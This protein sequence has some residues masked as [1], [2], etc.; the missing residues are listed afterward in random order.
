MQAVLLGG[1]SLILFRIYLKY[2]RPTVATSKSLLPDSFLFLNKRGNKEVRI[3]RMVTTFFKINSKLPLHL[4][5][6]ACRSMY[7]TEAANL[8]T[9][10]K[11]SAA[12]KNAVTFLGGHGGTVV[13]NNYLKVKVADSVESSRHLMS[14]ISGSGNIFEEEGEEEREEEEDNGNCPF[15]DEEEDVYGEDDSYLKILDSSFPGCEHP[16]IKLTEKKRF[17]WSSAENEYMRKLSKR[18]MR[19]DPD[20]EKTICKRMLAEI[21][22]DQNALKIFHPYHILSSD[23]LRGGWFS[24]CKKDEIK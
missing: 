9:D 15:F 8:Q 24:L 2:A 13:K 12:T 22:K 21:K 20:A 4:T 6:T 16:Q 18:I 19:T 7:E 3:G 1:D 11:I 14:A 17:C 5:T 10:G 23:R